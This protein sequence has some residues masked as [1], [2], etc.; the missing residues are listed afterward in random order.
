MPDDAAEI[1]PGRAAGRARQEGGATGRRLAWVLWPA[2]ALWAAVV[3]GRAARELAEVDV[4]VGLRRTWQAPVQA[5]E[6][7][8]LDP[9][10]VPSL[11]V[12]IAARY[13]PAAGPGLSTDPPADGWIS[14][15]AAIGLPAEPF[16]ADRWTGAPPRLRVTADGTPHLLIG[17]LGLDPIAVWPG[18]GVLRID[19][20]ALPP[21]VIDLA[22][23]GAREPP[24]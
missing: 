7:F 16:T 6:G 1:P 17:L 13:A 20:G 11:L 4:V 15:L 3:V 12:E 5:A 14:A 8:V 9:R 23:I 24:W 18:R 10:P 2:M 22:L 21:A 19:E